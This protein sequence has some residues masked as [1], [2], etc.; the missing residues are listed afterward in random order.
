MGKFKEDMKQFY[1]L[2]TVLIAFI[3]NVDGQTH[4]FD[5]IIEGKFYSF[6]DYY[7]N[8]RIKTLGNYN[9]TIKT[10]D[11]IYFTRKGDKLAFGLYQDNHKIGNWTYY[12]KKNVYRIKWTEKNK[13]SVSS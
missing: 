10:G 13:P 8:G 5:T 7:N 11:W 1:L 12:D 3:S 4:N 6:V 9:D 2:F